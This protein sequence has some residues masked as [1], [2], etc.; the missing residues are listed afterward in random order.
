MSSIQYFDPGM[1]HNAVRFKDFLKFTPSQQEPLAETPFSTMQVV[2]ITLKTPFESLISVVFRALAHLTYYANRKI[3]LICTVLAVQMTRD[4]DQLCKYWEIGSKLVVTTTYCP[5]IG[6]SDAYTHPLYPIASIQNKDVKAFVWDEIQPSE[7]QS[8]L[9]EEAKAAKYQEWMR[10]EK[11][12][13]E[14]ALDFFSQE[15][16]SHGG[17]LLFIHYLLS[18]Q[19]KEFEKGIKKAAA[20]FHTGFPRQATILNAFRTG[21][22]ERALDLKKDPQATISLYELNRHPNRAKERLAALPEG[23]YQ[24]TILN[25]SCVYVKTEKDTYAFDLN[26]GLLKISAEELFDRMIKYYH[27]EDNPEAEMTVYK[28][29]RK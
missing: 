16:F 23:T 22:P 29:T 3:S 2:W 6:T 25:N 24:F 28:Y 12:N 14:A 13:K 9:S 8:A 17:T 18:S 27:E 5:Q 19:E 1:L 7:Y 20:H 10:F 11:K 15:G 21:Y 26:F 4:W